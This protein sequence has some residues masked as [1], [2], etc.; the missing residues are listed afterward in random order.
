M[1]ADEEGDL[2]MTRVEQNRRAR[3]AAHEVTTVDQTN[4]EQNPDL[5][6][7]LYGRWRRTRRSTGTSRT[8]LR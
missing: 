6:D 8:M 3:L 1:N 2:P 5:R 4:P 7:A